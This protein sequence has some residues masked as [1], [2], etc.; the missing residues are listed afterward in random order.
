MTDHVSYDLGA[1]EITYRMANDLTG[2][3]FLNIQIL[4]A[5]PNYDDGSPATIGYGARVTIK[6][7]IINWT[8]DFYAQDKLQAVFRCMWLSDI[9]LQQACLQNG[10]EIFSLQPGDIKQDFDVYRA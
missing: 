10:I 4:N 3:I 8:H 6:S 5:E 7:E 1:R 2:T 9:Y